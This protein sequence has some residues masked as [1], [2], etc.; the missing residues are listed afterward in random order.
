LQRGALDARERTLKEKERE[1]ERE[2]RK[3]ARGHLLDARQTIEKVIA[4]LK[5]KGAAELDEAA[6]TA[7]RVVETE[8]QRQGRELERLLDEQ[9]AKAAEVAR[10]RRGGVD[11]LPEVGELVEASAFGNRVGTLIEVKNGL[12]TVAIGALKMS[13]PVATLR[14]TG[15][16]P[17][18]AAV[19]VAISNPDEDT[20]PPMGAGEVDLR[21]MRVS[22]ID[23]FVS[24]AIDTAVRADLKELRIIHGKGTGALR[25]R[26]TSMLR[27]ES[28]VAAHRMGLWNEGG[29]GVTIAELR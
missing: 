14:A 10:E 12:G 9:R 19:T 6:R 11:R 7:R 1:F 24:R 2:S 25:E 15:R 29:A 8:A 16:K 20:G 18:R 17:E 5:A 4:E 22:E 26:V 13:F 23:D 28:R 3:A 21:G 27:N